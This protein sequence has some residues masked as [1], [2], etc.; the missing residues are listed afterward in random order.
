[1]HGS[2]DFRRKVK[3]DVSEMGGGDSRPDNRP[4]SEV[5]DFCQR[6][7]AL[8]ESRF[9]PPHHHVYLLKRDKAEGEFF[10]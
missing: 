9:T 6:Y 2:L 5:G 10:F 4:P 7:T 3:D 8:T 1:M